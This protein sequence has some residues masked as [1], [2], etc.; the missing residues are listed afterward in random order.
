M[1]MMIS[2]HKRAW[3]LGRAASASPFENSQE[4]LEIIITAAAANTYLA[5]TVYQAHF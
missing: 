5:L 4:E 1:T 2:G 3:L